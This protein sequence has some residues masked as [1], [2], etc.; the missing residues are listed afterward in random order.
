MFQGVESLADVKPRNIPV[1]SNERYKTSLRRPLSLVE[2]SSGIH[3]TANST[4]RNNVEKPKTNLR[5]PLSLVE[6][7]SVS[8][9]KVSIPRTID[10]PSINAK[11][12]RR[13]KLSEE[14]ETTSS[15]TSNPV[16]LL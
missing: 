8:A 3:T 16:N 15:K 4:C 12:V 5:R 11:I 9:R 1:R 7:S 2:G 13:N 10:K 14:G 6:D